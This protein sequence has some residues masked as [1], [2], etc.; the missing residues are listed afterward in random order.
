M[1]KQTQF[2]F[3][4]VAAKGDDRHVVLS[5]IFISGWIFE[6]RLDVL[7][8]DGSADG[9]GASFLFVVVEVAVQRGGGVVGVSAFELT[10]WEVDNHDLF[11]W[12]FEGEDGWFW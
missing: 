9:L 1:F 8:D 5:Y 11:F 3:N 7:V 6:D 12:H 2:V 10:G 4:A